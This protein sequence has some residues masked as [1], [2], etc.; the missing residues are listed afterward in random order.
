[1]FLSWGDETSP[2]AVASAGKSRATSAC[3]ATAESVVV[4]PIVNPS[5]ALPRTPAIS[6]MARSPTST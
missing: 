3:S 1:M 4:A 5:R 2:A 6:R